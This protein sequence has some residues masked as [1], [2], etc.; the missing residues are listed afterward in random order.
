MHGLLQLG[1]CGPAASKIIA[2]VSD[3]A[4][5]LN[6]D[7]LEHVNARQRYKVHVV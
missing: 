1:F 7:S 4:S 2:F 3:A 6:L 5:P